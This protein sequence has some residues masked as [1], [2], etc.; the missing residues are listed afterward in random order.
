MCNDPCCAAAKLTVQDGAHASNDS[1]ATSRPKQ[2]P[3]QAAFGRRRRLVTSSSP[4]S[5]W[6]CSAS[7]CSLQPAGLVTLA[8]PVSRRCCSRLLPLTAGLDRKRGRSSSSQAKKAA[9]RAAQLSSCA[10]RAGKVSSSGQQHFSAVA[11][12]RSCSGDTHSKNQ[13]VSS[14]LSRPHLGVAVN[15]RRAQQLQQEGC[16]KGQSAA[17]PGAG[18]RR[19]GSPRRQRRNR[20]GGQ[21]AR[22]QVG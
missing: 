20:E 18:P 6:R 13:S 2:I 16:G 19:A 7:A 4:D 14:S 17:V 21:P 3:S 1:P 15:Q 22:G 12:T 11:P 5:S 8:A 10:T 9:R